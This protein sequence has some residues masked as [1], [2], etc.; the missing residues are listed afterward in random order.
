MGEH[1]VRAL[2]MGGQACVFYGAAEFS[3]DTDLAIVADAANLARLRRALDDLQAEVIA[4][5]PFELKYLRRG[6][7]IH[8]RC[9]HPEALRMRVDVMARMRGVPAFPKLWDR[10]TTF[11]LPDGM[12]CDLLSLPDLVLAK[13]TQRDKDWPMIRRLVEAHYFQNSGKPGSAQIR[14]WLRELRTP[15][16]LVETAQRHPLSSRRMTHRRPLLAHAV[17]GEMGKLEQALVDEEFAER[18]RDRAYW[19]PLRKEL[20]TFRREEIGLVR[21]KTG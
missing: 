2:L 15:Q 9:R 8:F 4:V 12:R 3:R 17:L 5:P 13:K 14:F 1:R 10:R 19:S 16:L 11:E 7:A 6:H 20:E 21:G 18:K